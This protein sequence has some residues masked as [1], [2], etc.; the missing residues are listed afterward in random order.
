MALLLL[1]LALL[2]VNGDDAE[3]MAKAEALVTMV[4]QMGRAKFKFWYDEESEAVVWNSVDCGPLLKQEAAAVVAAPALLFDPVVVCTAI[5]GISMGQFWVGSQLD[6]ISMLASEL[7][8]PALVALVLIAVPMLVIEVPFGKWNHLV[9][10]PVAQYLVA[11]R[12]AAQARQ[13]VP[14]PAPRRAHAVAR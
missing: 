3:M 1:L 8:T 9:F 5:G 14:V 6:T 7:Y 12:E 2:L 11:V 13:P 4:A 10:R